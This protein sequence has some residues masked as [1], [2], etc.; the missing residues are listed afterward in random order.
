MI[1][2]FLRAFAPRLLL[3]ALAGLMFYLLEPGFHLHEQEPSPDAFALDLG[4]LGISAT[5]ANLAGLG[6]L[7]LLAGFISADRRRGYYRLYFSHPT[8]PLAFYG[9]RWL[10]AVLL[11]VAAAAVF[12]VVGQWAAWGE[13]QGGGRGLLLALL[14]AVAYGGLIAFLSAVLPFGDAWVAI[15]LFFFGF[16]WLQAGTLGLLEPLPLAL[17][18]VV[19]LLL[20]PQIPMQDV[21][22]G[23]LRGE[24]AWGGVGFTLGYGLFWLT[25]A[26][27]LVRLREWP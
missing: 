5:L 3:V 20:P 8:R 27:L 2:V 22:D 9:T 1:P 17:R 10:L 13:F 23:L 24:V 11:A 12:L 4:P 7:I 18:Q 19:T 6:V 16:F 25:L 21:Y 26:A 14:A 15:G